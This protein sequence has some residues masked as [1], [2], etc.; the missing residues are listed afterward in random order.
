R[1]HGVPVVR[2][3]KYA[4]ASD[5]AVTS[6]APQIAAYR[7]AVLAGSDGQVNGELVF[8]RGGTTIRALPALDSGAEAAALVMAAEGLAQALAVHTIDAFPR[9]PPGPAACEALGCGYARRCWGRAGSDRC[10]D[11]R[12]RHP[13]LL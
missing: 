12:A 8:L 13:V 4:A 11:R 1:R 5:A 10:A 3:F 9:T 6:Y 7:L 2:D